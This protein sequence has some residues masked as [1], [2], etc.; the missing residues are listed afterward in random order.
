MTG[1]ASL[2]L[3]NSFFGGRSKGTPDYGSS[4]RSLPFTWQEPG[5]GTNMQ[6]IE[7][8]MLNMS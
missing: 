1:D 4:D 6:C 2:H 7:R 5:E 8:S 3:L